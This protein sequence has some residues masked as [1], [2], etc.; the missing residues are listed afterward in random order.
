M[1]IFSHAAA[2]AAMGSAFGRPLTGAF[3]ALMPDFFL[4]SIKRVKLPTP[5]YTASHSLPFAAIIGATGA[6]VGFG[7]VVFLALLSH[8]LLDLPTHGKLWAPALFTPF[9]DRRYSFGEEWEFF[10]DSWI[11]GF[12]ITLTWSFLWLAIPLLV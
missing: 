3:F 2:G 9:S 6:L 4:L 8:I 10:N 12:I 5:M 7:P 11:L 1:D